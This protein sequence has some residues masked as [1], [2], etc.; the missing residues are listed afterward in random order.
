MEDFLPSKKEKNQH[1]IDGKATFHMNNHQEEDRNPPSFATPINSDPS[2]IKKNLSAYIS[3]KPGNPPITIDTSTSISLTPSVKDFVGPI[4]SS[5]IN[6]LRGLD[7]TIA[8][9][10]WRRDCFLDHLR[11]PGHTRLIE[12]VTH[13]VPDASIHLF[14]L[15][16]TSKNV[17][18]GVFVFT[19]EGLP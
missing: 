11:C 15:R 1:I 4:C 8:V 14:H 9:C 17:A 7:Q 2:L 6:S 13:C 19:I 12:T 16:L 18:M 10:R 5:S 3:K